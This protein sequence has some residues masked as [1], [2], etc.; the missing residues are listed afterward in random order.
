M[1]Q[2]GKAFTISSF[3]REMLRGGEGMLFPFGFRE[4]LK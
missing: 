1:S 4:H 3:L 2:K